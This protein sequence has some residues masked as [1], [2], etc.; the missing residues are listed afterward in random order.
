MFIRGFKKL[1]S[2]DFP[3]CLDTAKICA[4]WPNYGDGYYYKNGMRTMDR[5]I[6]IHVYTIGGTGLAITESTTIMINGV[7]VQND[8]K[9]N[10]LK[11]VDYLMLCMNLETTDPPVDTAK[12]KEKHKK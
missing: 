3:L 7:P 8:S 9:D 1:E 2:V 10:A 4:V 6:N 12:L 11:I 5:S